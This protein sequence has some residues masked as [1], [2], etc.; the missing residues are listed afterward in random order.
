MTSFAREDG[1][2]MLSYDEDLYAKNAN[3]KH[4]TLNDLLDELKLVRKS[5][6]AQYKSYTKEM[7][8]KSG[9]GFNGT[10]YSVLAMAF[11]IAGHQ[12]WHFRVLEEKYYPLLNMQ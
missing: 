10:E 6:I 3:A 7:L 1:Q 2:K 5:Y 12:R 11:M 9:K 4:R 8:L